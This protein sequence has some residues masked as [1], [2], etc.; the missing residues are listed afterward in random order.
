MR[1][2][3][4]YRTTDPKILKEVEDEI[5]SVFGDECVKFQGHPYNL[6]YMVML[7]DVDDNMN[8]KVVVTDEGVILKDISNVVLDKRSA[9]ILI[10]FLKY[11]ALKH[12]MAEA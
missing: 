11:N 1:K 4:S 10:E 5:G 8:I 12:T 9:G 7:K 3:L 2:K 6:Y